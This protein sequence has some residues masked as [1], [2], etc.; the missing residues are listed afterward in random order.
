MHYHINN[1]PSDYFLKL[2]KVDAESGKQIIL[3]DATFKVKDL[4]T[5]KYVRQKV[6]GVW[7][8]EFNTDKDGYVILP[9]K[10]KSGKYQLEEI[11]A[12]YNY[13]LNGTSIPFEIKKSEVTS[14]DE[15]GD[16][17][18][19][20]T[21]EDTRVK[22]SISFEKRGEV[23]VGSHEDENG[24]IVFDYEEQGLEG[25]TVTVYAKEDI[26]DPADGTVIYKAGE[27]V[28][29]ATTDKSGKTQVDNLYLGSYIV[30]ETQ[31]PEGFV[32]SDKEY[33]VTLS[34]KDDH[35]AIISDSVTYLNDR[36]KVHIDLRKVDEDNEA[37][38]QGAVFGLYASE[39]I[40]GVEKLSKTNSKPLIIK[41]G[42]LIET[43]TSDEN[44]QVVFNADLPLSKYE[45][46]ELKA[47]I[48]YASSDEVIPVDATYK[49]QELPTIEIVA[50][51]KNK[52]TQVEFSKVDASTNEELEGATQIVYPKG[53]RGEVFETWVSTKEPHII[54]GLEVGQTYIWEEISAP[55]GFAL[56]E[57]IEFTVKDT[58]EVQV[59][60]TMKDEIVY[61]QLAFE[62]K[63][64]QFTYTDIGMTD[65]GMVNTPVFEEMNILGAEITIYA[66][67]DITLG[68]GITYY[69][70]DEEID[71]LVSDYEAV[72]SIKL[73]VGKY[74][75]VETKAP[76]GFVKN[77]EKHYF[78]VVDNQINELQVIESTLK[79]ERPV[80]NINMTKQ[81]EFSDT[82]MNKEAYKDVVFGIYTRD[83]TYDWKGNVAIEPDTLLATSG[84]D[85]E[86]HLVHTPELPVGNYY[87]KELQ[88]NSAYKLDENEYDFSIDQSNEKA[89]IVPI[90]EGKPIIN[91]LKE[92]YV[93]V[94][95]VD[96]NTMKNIISKEFEFTSFTDAECKNP[97]ETKQANTKDGTV[98]FVLNY[99]TTYIKE[100][101]APL[102]YSLS[103]EVVKVEV[104]DDGLFVNGK[105]VE[106]S[107]DLLYSIIYK[108]SLLPVIQTGA[109]SDSMLF[110]VAG[111]G[112][113]VSLI[114]IL[115]Y[116]RRNKNKK[117]E[118]KSE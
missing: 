68:N 112:V 7:I 76:I 89:V 107:E 117:S 63:G 60:G 17:Y 101:K 9:L 1:R 66:G 4:S 102:G 105:K 38:L 42:T 72:Q 3:S 67:E 94:N 93:L 29:T 80:Y 8:D 34:Y 70:A 12:P 57:K 103:P 53:N 81:M 108:D 18:I 95:K 50:V 27:V 15:D 84:I 83:D 116:R 28:T 91:K 44:G 11:K 46:R 21:M 32:I 97:I 77:E 56:A 79:N 48:G 25:M 69:K 111:L 47:P 118:N 49:G 23:L 115:E 85:E 59:A 71:T 22:G 74:Y 5:G 54:K 65:L 26:I 10:L 90:N 16:A 110:I 55:Y 14:E 52:I 39:D 73:P 114:G 104:N 96:E 51:F 41:K 30:R 36:Q 62:K 64:K 35:T 40:Y 98:K 45:I 31:A 19:V 106:R 100:T 82:A 24:N 58:G 33:E 75:Y 43:A 88:T 2:V 37:N 99:G 113:L 6:A 78:E 20:V 61:G 87:L 13:L 86:G 92:Y 109:G